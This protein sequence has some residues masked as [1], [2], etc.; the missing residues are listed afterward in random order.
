MRTKGLLQISIQGSFKVDKQDISRN[1][2]KIREQIEQAARKA[3]RKPGEITVVAVSKY[4]PI[5][6]IKWA[7]EL[8][9]MDFGENYIQ[10]ALEKN[11]KV[12]RP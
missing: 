8:G 7:R 4:Q 6:Y 1:L 11:G 9:Q 5:E 12:R 10:E 2:D 3:G